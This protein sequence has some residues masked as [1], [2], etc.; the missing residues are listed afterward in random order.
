M[1]LKTITSGYIIYYNLYSPYYTTTIYHN[2]KELIDIDARH[3]DAL[4]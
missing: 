3:L 4:V 1:T 2:S